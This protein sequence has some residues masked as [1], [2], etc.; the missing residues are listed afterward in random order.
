MTK[1]VY[2]VNEEDVVRARNQL[3]ASLLYSI[4]SSGGER[5]P[6]RVPA[7]PFFSIEPAAGNTPGAI[8]T[9]NHHM[10]VCANE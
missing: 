9:V 8:R 10:C 5:P 6:G 4:D 2:E 1:L 7:I 3:K